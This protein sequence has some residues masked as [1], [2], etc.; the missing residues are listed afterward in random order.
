M[1]RLERIETCNQCNQRFRILTGPA[2][3]SPYLTAINCPYCD[4]RWGSQMTGAAL[5]TL[6]LGPSDLET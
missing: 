4:T 6:K 1:G 5:V 2:E 3:H